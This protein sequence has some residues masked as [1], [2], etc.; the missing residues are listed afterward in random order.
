[1]AFGLVR[2]GLGSDPSPREQQHHG[3]AGG[4]QGNPVL[5]KQKQR[6]A[7]EHDNADGMQIGKR[8]QQGSFTGRAGFGAASIAAVADLAKSRYT[9]RLRALG[10]AR[11]SLPKRSMAHNI[12]V[13]HPP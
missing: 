2:L 6:D 13:R 7:G 10:S 9:A 11:L 1:M 5:G 8:R 3:Q 12:Y 4:L